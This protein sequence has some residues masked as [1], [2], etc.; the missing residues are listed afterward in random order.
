NFLAF[1]VGASVITNRH[2]VDRDFQFRDLGYHFY[3]K[4]E[5]A[6]IDRKVANDLTAKSFV[7][8]FDVGHVEVGKRVRQV[9]QEFISKVVIKIKYAR[10][11][12][13]QKPGAKDD[14]SVA[15]QN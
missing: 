6:R 10:R 2:F 5:A 8:G 1:G 14:I 7:T 13:N 4:T 3:F 12:P 15:L 9:G 11:S